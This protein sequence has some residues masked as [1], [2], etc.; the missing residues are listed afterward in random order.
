MDLSGHKIILGS[1]SPRRKELMAG[2]DLDFTVE[3]GTDC[4]ESYDPATPVEEIPMA[5]ATAKSHGFHRKLSDDEILITADT[6][7]FCGTRKMGKPKT[8]EEAAAMLRELSGKTHTVTTGVF[9]RTNW[10]NCGFSCSSQVTFKELEDS[11]IYYYIDKY[12]PFDK[13]GGYGIQEWIGYI[14][15]TS[16]SGSYYNIMGLPVQ[17]LYT[18]LKEF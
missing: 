14:G 4:D 16:I 10:K 12:R 3:M 17:R 1:A 8:R 9:I 5:I 2:L 11:E 7:V 18:A 13:A 15:I 6:L